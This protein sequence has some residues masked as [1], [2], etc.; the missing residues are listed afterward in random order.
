[1]ELF[2]LDSL[3]SPTNRLIL[4]RLIFCLIGENCNNVSSRLT[5][6]ERFNPPFASCHYGVYV[7]LTLRAG[8]F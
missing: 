7:N 6:A 4:N 1:M 5:D 2:I 8:H 3:Y